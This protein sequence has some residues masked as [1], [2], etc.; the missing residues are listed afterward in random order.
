MK[1]ARL[2]P[3]WPRRFRGGRQHMSEALSGQVHAA[4]DGA[5]L[6]RAM[7]NKKVSPAQAR[8]RIADI[9]HRG[10]EMRA[11]LVD[12]L[13][14]TLVAPLD[15]EDLFR[16]SRS[17]DDVLDTI[18]EFLREA[19]LYQIQRRKTYRPFLDH[20][21]AAV[22]SLDEAVGTLWSAPHDVPLKALDAKKAARSISR[23]YQQEFARIVDGD[24]SPDA[25]KHRELIKRLDGVGARIS[26]AADVLT[27]GALKRGY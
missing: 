1:A 14:R 27:D 15:R 6:A 12:R 16:L 11:V 18:R 5:A 21:V 8:E 10:D 24:M 20:V 9:E 4:R 2:R 7:V 22:D 13:S 23:E 25:L 17:I 19:D 3:R 26:E